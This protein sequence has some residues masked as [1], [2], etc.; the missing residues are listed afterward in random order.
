MTNSKSNSAQGAEQAET[1]MSILMQPEAVKPGDPVTV[2]GLSR[3]PESIKLNGKKISFRWNRNKELIFTA[4]EH[5][6]N[7]QLS[8]QLPGSKKVVSANALMVASD[9]TDA[10]KINR[11]AA[12]IL[13]PP[14]DIFVTSVSPLSG[15]PGTDITIT[16]G[17]FDQISSVRI[18][19]VQALLISNDGVSRIV[20][21]VQ[22]GTPTGLVT[23]VTLFG[24]SI[25][26]GKTFTVQTGVTI[27]SLTPGSGRPGD[28]ITITGS[29]FA[30]PF[31]V[32][33]G[34]VPALN[35][36]LVNSSTLRARV[37]SQAATGV[38][39]V[40]TPNGSATSPVLFVV[41]SGT[42]PVITDFNPKTAAPDFSPV[43][44]TGSGFTG[45]IGVTF[46]G[47]AAAATFINDGRIEAR[48]PLLA[49]NGPITVT[50]SAGTVQS[51]VSFTVGSS[52][53]MR[54]VITSFSPAFGNVGSTVQ[55]FGSNFIGVSQV[56]IG[57]AIVQS[58]QVSGTT[59]IQAVVPANAL[60][61]RIAVTNA[62]GTGI[63]PTDFNVTASGQAPRIDFFSPSSG[64]PGQDV[65]INGANFNDIRSVEFGGVPA[66]FFTTVNLSQINAKVPNGA[67]SGPITVRNGQFLAGT[68]QQSFTVNMVNLPPDIQ[69]VVVTGNTVSIAGIRLGQVSSVLFNGLNL[70]VTSISETL[71]TAF[72]SQGNMSGTYTVIAGNGFSDS[73]FYTPPA[74]AAPDIQSVTVARNMAT[75][76]GINLAGVV[77]V[78]FL[79]NIG[80]GFGSLSQLSIVGTPTNTRVQAV[81][82]LGNVA[83]R[84]IV[85]TA[86][87]QSDSFDYFPVFF[88][89]AGFD[90]PGVM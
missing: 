6:G 60:T 47:A 17:G 86:G 19:G 57:G 5:V 12:I 77:A 75:L 14:S 22:S 31:T 30:A 3:K 90:Q 51:A 37:P 64:S 58:F 63:S 84:Y 71:I 29:G 50:T 78:G 55:I 41:L 74:N 45:L 40:S 15:G 82:P 44:I 79:R 72:N 67:L 88:T 66:T 56:A 76:T 80:G 26:S 27:T 73:F 36:T 69:S 70:M 7:G 2:T 83:G 24:Q 13:P 46:N 65:V 10:G 9:E 87:G 20:A 48:V 33:F 85:T 8:I 53:D 23:L 35:P 21:R 18:G 32:Q 54:P 61:G 11:D 16:G 49:T 39:S 89:G 4:P 62:S 52:G 42:G 68:S 38:V 81:N 59:L 34:G 28:E 1:A 25:S 43:V